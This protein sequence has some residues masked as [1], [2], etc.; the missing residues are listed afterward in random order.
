MTCWNKGLLLDVSSLMTI[1]DQSEGFILALAT[2]KLV[3][4]IDS[5]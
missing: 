1:F 3:Y 4:D 2:L 5:R